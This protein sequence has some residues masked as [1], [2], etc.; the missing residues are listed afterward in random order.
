MPTASF[1]DLA[2]RAVPTT[3][4]R[5]LVHLVADSQY[6]LHWL[7]HLGPD[8]HEC[9]IATS[10]AIG[11]QYDAV[12]EWP[13]PPPP[14]LVDLAAPRRLQVCADSIAEFLRRMWVENEIFAAQTRRRALHPDAHTYA[15][16]LGIHIEDRTQRSWRPRLP[17]RGHPGRREG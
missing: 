14:D 17:R 2:E 4:G 7:V 1:I 6:V 10:D 11:W 5:V 12:E 8:G 16:G 13:Q 3:D 9:M 15:Q